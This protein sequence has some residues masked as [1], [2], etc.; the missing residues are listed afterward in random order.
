ML[1]GGAGR[2]AEARQGA[3]PR[4]APCSSRIMRGIRSNRVFDGL[5]RTRLDEL[6]GRLGLEYRRL[7]GEGIDAL[8]RLG[9]GL[10]DDHELCEAR[11]H[12]GSGLLELLVAD[13]RKRLDDA[14]DVFSRQGAGVLVRN[15]LNE[16]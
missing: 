10:L 6:P 2:H 16:F 5:D 3:L 1:N 9:G 13:A 8:A 11:Q 14:L 7:L 15:C 12:E 4:S